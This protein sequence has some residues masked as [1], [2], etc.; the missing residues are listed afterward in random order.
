MADD[1]AFLA[2]ETAA[3]VR[4]GPDDGELPGF[5]DAVFD[6]VV[7]GHGP[8]DTIGNGE[9]GVRADASGVAVLDAAKLVYDLR[10]GGAVGHG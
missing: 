1:A 9:D 7:F 2:G 6:E 8:G 4:A 5:S 3:A 10:R